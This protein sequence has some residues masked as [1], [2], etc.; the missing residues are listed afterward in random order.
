MF[1]APMAARRRE[2]G[3]NTVF[4]IAGA[5]VV[6]AFQVGKAPMAL[7]AIQVDLGISLVLVSWLISAFAIVGAIAGAPVGLAADR[8][9]AKRMIVGGLVVQAVGAG[10]GAASPG[11]EL[12]LISRV[13]EGLGFMGVLI[14]GPAM[15]FG[16]V[17]AKIHNRAISVWATVM[18]VGMTTVMFAAPLLTMLEWRGFWSLN[19]AILFAY[20]VFFVVMVSA[21][22]ALIEDGGSISGQLRQALSAPG[23]WVLAVM[24]AAF[25]AAFFVVFGFL[26]SLLTQRFGLSSELASTISGV[27]IAASGLGNLAAG[28]LLASGRK[29]LHVLGTGFVLMALFGCG[30]LAADLFLTAVTVLAVLF[31]FVAGLIPVVIMDSVPRLAP[32]AELVGATLGLAMQGNNIGML[33]GPVVGGA[34]A[35]SFG[36]TSVAIAL[37]IVSITV[38]LLAN[39]AFRQGSR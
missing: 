23:P 6:S 10:L 18:P 16:S 2:T 21:R 22:K 29:P 25:S 5:G 12:L 7:G 26:P 39:R 38:I 19:A 9:G 30:V 34:L 11:V 32:R 3:W 20:A 31:A 15:I 1:T 37:A 17:P 24:F 35:A 27:A 36:W 33:V 14:A 4:I 28:F 13:V 8:I